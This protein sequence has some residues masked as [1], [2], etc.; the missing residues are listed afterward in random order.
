MN[1]QL[2]EQWAEIIVPCWYS[3]KHSIKDPQHASSLSQYL[4]NLHILNHLKSSFHKDADTYCILFWL[5]WFYSSK[6]FWLM[7][8]SQALAA[9]WHAKAHAMRSDS[10]TECK[11][12]IMQWLADL[13]KGWGVLSGCIWKDA[14]FIR[15]RSHWRESRRE[16]EKEM[17]RKRGGNYRGRE[18]IREKALFKE[19]MKW[20]REGW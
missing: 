15:S 7:Q 9:H 6:Y 11:A 3:S 10:I 16:R 18:R 12:L 8:T 2:L 17:E 1:G 13:D 14:A 20:N 19:R 4:N 5:C